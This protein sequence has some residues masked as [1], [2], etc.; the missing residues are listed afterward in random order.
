MIKAT[1]ATEIASEIKSYTEQVEQKLQ[2][3]LG[4][5]VEQATLAASSSTPI[6]NQLS[7]ISGKNNGT[8]GERLYYELYEKRERNFGIE[9]RPGFHRGAWGYSGSDYFPESTTIRDPIDAARNAGEEA[10]YSHQLGTPLY[11]GA[12]GP[13]FSFLQKGDSAQAPDGIGV[14]AIAKILAIDIK[15]LYDSSLLQ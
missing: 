7:I 2:Q 9:I 12:K 1:N 10:T 4:K 13:G 15:D 14:L 3:M 8:E 5:F 6:G 11:I